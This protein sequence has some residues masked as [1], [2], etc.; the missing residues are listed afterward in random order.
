MDDWR[1]S[2]FRN[3]GNWYLALGL[4]GLVM[5]IYVPWLAAQRTTRVEQRAE[6]IASLLAA[7][8]AE[9]DGDFTA[10][11][12]EVLAARF[13]RRVAADG[14]FAADLEVATTP[15]SA[16]LRFVNKHYTLQLQPSPPSPELPVG[17]DATL[18]F[19]VVA[20]P[21]DDAGP[22]HSKYFFPEHGPRAFT[23]NLAGR[24]SAGAG[25]SSPGSC[26]P[27]PGQGREGQRAYRSADDERWL[28]YGRAKGEAAQ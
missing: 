9:F 11:R 24:Y 1:P 3:P 25:E 10:E 12:C 28:L 18:P 17:R 19:E 6:R 13:L 2:P 16:W 8:A 27:V 14:E 7:T 21:R 15:G 20:W 22:G 4:G 26:H 23:R 5:T